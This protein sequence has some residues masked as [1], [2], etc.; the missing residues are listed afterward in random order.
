MKINT[1]YSPMCVVSLGAALEL[2]LEL[3]S[4]SLHLQELGL[5]E[6]DT[7]RLLLSQELLWAT[8]VQLLPYVQ[9]GS[10]H[11]TGQGSS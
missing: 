5:Q 7:K 11:P 8:S 3:A 9:E 1:F 2:Y 4:S 6:E 10:L